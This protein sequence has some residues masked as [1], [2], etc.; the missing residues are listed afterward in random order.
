[1]PISGFAAARIGT[2]PQRAGGGGASAVSILIMVGL[3]P[4]GLVM[5]MVLA[6]LLVQPPGV[7]C[8]VLAVGNGTAGPETY[9]VFPQSIGPGK[10]GVQL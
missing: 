3:V 7:I 10:G 9:T 5:L 8:R 6:L 2:T 4:L 1:M